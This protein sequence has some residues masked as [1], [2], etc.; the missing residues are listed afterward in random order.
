MNLRLL[1]A[2][3]C[4]PDGELSSF[5]LSKFGECD[6]SRYFKQYGSLYLEEHARHDLYLSDPVV[7][8]A[9]VL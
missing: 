2:S 9:S 6:V 8:F 5:G 3:E 7:R 4:L 1:Y